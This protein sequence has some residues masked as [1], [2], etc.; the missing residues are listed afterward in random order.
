MHWLD[1]TMVALLAAAAVLGAWSGFV[2]QVFKLVG[3][4]AALYA[5]SCLNAWGSSWLASGLMR[6]AETRVC[7][8]VAFALTFLLIYLAIFLTSLLLER[9]VEATQLQFLNRSLGAALAVSKMAVLLG[10]LAYGLQ[11][12]PLESVKQVLEESVVAPLLAQGAENVVNVIPDDYKNE[13]QL[14]WQQ[15]QEALPATNFRP[16][17]AG[18]D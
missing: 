10:A 5:A 14:G 11:R 16:K 9:G 1:S 2:M 13:W 4:G 17:G 15:V 18:Q 8:A 7:S 12:L 6:G 3:F